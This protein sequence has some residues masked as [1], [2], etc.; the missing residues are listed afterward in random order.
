MTGTT[1][2]PAEIGPG[3]TA[4]RARQRGTLINFGTLAAIGFVVGLAAAFVENEDA[5]ISAGGTMPGWFAI[6]APS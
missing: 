2:K 3:E 5:P 1:L 4:A 6:L